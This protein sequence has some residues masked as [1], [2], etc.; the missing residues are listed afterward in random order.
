ME[1]KSAIGSI[2]NGLYE[3]AICF[4]SNAAAGIDTTL[5]RVHCPVGSL[6]ADQV[7]FQGESYS[8]RVGS[9]CS[10]PSRGDAALFVIGEFI[11][12]YRRFIKL[13][14]GCCMD[15][16]PGCAE[17]VHGIQRHWSIVMC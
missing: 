12:S 15:F 16:V 11:L 3:R 2:A 1:T 14:I 9:I 6:S 10:Q 13:K 8:V 17:E 7:S 5:V 4:T